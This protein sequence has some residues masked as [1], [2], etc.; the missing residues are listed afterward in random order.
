M[1]ASPLQAWNKFVT[2]SFPDEQFTQM[3]RS[4]LLADLKRRIQ[5]VGETPGSPGWWFRA[6]GVACAV[7]GERAHGNMVALVLTIA[8]AVINQVLE[9]Q[10]LAMTMSHTLIVSVAW[11]QVLVLQRKW[12]VLSNCHLCSFKNQG[13]QSKHPRAQRS[14]GGASLFI[15]CAEMVLFRLPNAHPHV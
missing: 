15:H 14:Q 5:Q 11:L 9:A 3:W 12:H 7:L 8:I 10:K 2:I 4:T 1:F 13:V 6:D